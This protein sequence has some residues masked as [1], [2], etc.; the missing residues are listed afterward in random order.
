MPRPLSQQR[1][2][3]HWHVKMDHMLWYHKSS[4]W[5]FVVNPKPRLWTLLFSLSCLISTH[6][7]SI[8]STGVGSS[9]RSQ[10]CTCT[11]IAH[12]EYHRLLISK[13]S[14]VDIAFYIS[15]ETQLFWFWDQTPWNWY[16]YRTLPPIANEDIEAILYALDNSGDLKVCFCTPNFNDCNNVLSKQYNFLEMLGVSYMLGNWCVCCL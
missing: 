15:L 3:G 1:Q 8:Q 7:S 2:L 13:A 5:W 14:L 4:M 10:I 12:C 6:L 16:C 9:L 11:Y